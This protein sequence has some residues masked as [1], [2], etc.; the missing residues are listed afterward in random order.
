MGPKD[1]RER[2][3]RSGY[4]ECDRDPTEAPPAMDHPQARVEDA[5]DVFR[6]ALTALPEGVIY[7]DRQGRIVASNPS[8]QRILGLTHEQLRSRT[9]LDPCW[10]ALR[11]DGSPFSAASHPAL[12]ALRTGKPQRDVTMKVLQPDGTSSWIL[13]QAEPVFHPGEPGP[14]AVVCSFADIT[15]ARHTRQALELAKLEAEESGRVKDKFVSLLAHDLRAP[16]AAAMSMVQMVSSDTE[17]P[18]PE[19]QREI[20]QAVNA[21]LQQQLTLIDDVLSM[22]RLR[23]G[24]LRA[25]KRS[26]SAGVLMAAAMG[27]RYQAERK[28]IR[29]LNEVPDSLQLAADPVLFGQVIQNLVSNA[30]KFSR[31]GGTVRLFVPPDH[32]ATLAVQD[33][34]VGID[35]KRLPDLFR[36]EVQTSTVGTAGERGTGMGLPLSRDIVAAHGGTL[37]VE[38]EP[39]RG[40]T[41]YVD[42]P[43]YRPIVLVVDDEADLRT[44][45]TRYLVRLGCEVIEAGNGE[46]ALK[47]LET[48]YPMLVI[49][50]IQMP[51]LD[52]FGLLDSIRR[53]P[54]TAEIPVIVVTVGT[55]VETRDQAFAKGAND[56]VTKPI[57]AHDFLPRVRRFLN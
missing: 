44:L 27:F 45:F 56:F 34:G 1:D 2:T 53:N 9:S 13:M 33:Q 35:P 19:P 18:L 15:H 26:I 11:E 55:D 32:P 41:F 52:G 36:S 20:L 42:L 25:H 5:G 43:P 39:D 37:R 4:L 40:S 16:I 54:E 6:T 49:T 12:E 50:D 38:S 51:K 47:L 46:E 31:R 17:P 22:T 28:G 57:A 21:R 24:K 30:I 29:L 48:A 7:Q 23:T 10:P 8:A 3:G 14:H